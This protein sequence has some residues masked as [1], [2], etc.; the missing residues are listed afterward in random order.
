MLILSLNIH[1]H[2]AL[3]VLRLKLCVC[4]SHDAFVLH[5]P[6]FTLFDSITLKKQIMKLNILKIFAL[7]FYFCFPGLFNDTLNHTT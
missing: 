6:H 4:I 7:P 5:A 2:I 1:V 3:Q